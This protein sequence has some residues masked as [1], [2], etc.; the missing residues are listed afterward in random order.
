MLPLG[1]WW[2]GV[3]HAMPGAPQDA[4]GIGCDTSRGVTC[5]LGYARGECARFPEGDGPDAVRFTISSHDG[6]AIG[7]YYVVE[8]NH[9]PFAHGRLEY[10]IAASAFLTPPESTTLA[11]Q[12]Q[13]YVESYVRRK[14]E[15]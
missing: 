15:C 1:D 12:A 6:A 14:K 13:A 7:L 10:S 3:C 9:H 2:T 11:R 8:R 5:N 4:G